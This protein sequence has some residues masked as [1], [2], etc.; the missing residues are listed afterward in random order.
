MM[1]DRHT[2]IDLP[3]FMHEMHLK[4]LEIKTSYMKAD[5]TSLLCLIYFLEQLNNRI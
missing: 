5:N 4:V 2:Y 3:P 1:M